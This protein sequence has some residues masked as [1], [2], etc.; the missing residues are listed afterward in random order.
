MSDRKVGARKN[1]NIWDNIFVLNAIINSV[2]KGKESP[3]D[4]EICDIDK[5]FDGLWVEECIDDIFEAGV[6]NDKLPLLYLENQ[7]K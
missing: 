2:I 1:R 6:D 4:L 3:V 7:R 5:C